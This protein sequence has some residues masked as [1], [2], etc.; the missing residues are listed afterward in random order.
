MIII[1]EE[2]FINIKKLQILNI[3]CAAGSDKSFSWYVHLQGTLAEATNGY[4]GFDTT[5]SCESREMAYRVFKEILAQVSNSGEV[6]ELTNN[7]VNTIVFD[8]EKQ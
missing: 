5:I 1:T 2:I 7:L 4:E 6:I 3:S 8:K